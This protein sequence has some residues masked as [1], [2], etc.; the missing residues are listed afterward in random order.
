[1]N[2]AIS[3]DT[4]KL[5]IQ[6]YQDNAN[7]ILAAGYQNKDILARCETFDKSG[8]QYLLSME[9]CVSLRV[10]Y[11]MDD[12]KKIH[13]IFVGVDSNNNDILPTSGSEPSALIVE[14]GLRC[15]DNCPPSSSLSP[16]S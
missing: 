15:P 16:S 12:S 6:T 8:I 3:L 7:T 2:H 4:A 5:M 10:Y 11:G 1:M 14:D 13:A 9:N